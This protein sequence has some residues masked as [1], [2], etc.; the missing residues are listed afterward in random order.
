MIR[1]NVYYFL[2]K[3]KNIACP[4]I[5]YALVEASWSTVHQVFFLLS[6]NQTKNSLR[7][8][9]LA[10]TC[11]GANNGLFSGRKYLRFIKYTHGTNKKG[12]LELHLIRCV[13]N[14]TRK[15]MCRQDPIRD[16]NGFRPVL[17]QWPNFGVDRQKR[18]DPHTAALLNQANKANYYS[19]YV[20][21]HVEEWKSCPRSSIRTSLR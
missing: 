2:T 7:P 12:G 15:E 21:M 19:T 6:E 10:S 17:L 9:R 4:A 5:R 13:T 18:G 3:R 8:Y 1:V 14:S 11:T 20:M 16:L